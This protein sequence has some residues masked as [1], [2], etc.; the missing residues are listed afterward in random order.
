M[1]IKARVI[2]TMDDINTIVIDEIA[3]SIK[4]VCPIIKTKSN[5]KVIGLT[6]KIHKVV[7][8]LSVKLGVYLNGCNYETAS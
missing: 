5:P 7:V 8:T 4:L 2:Q 6:L 1:N 3:A